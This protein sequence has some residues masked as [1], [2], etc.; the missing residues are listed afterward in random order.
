MSV[1]LVLGGATGIGAAGV[2]ALRGAGHRVVIADRNL[3]SARALAAEDL[4][5]DAFAIE[6]DLADPDIPR[7]AVA[8]ASEL[9]GGTI[10]VV[11]YNA[12]VLISHPL[13]EWTTADWGRSVAVN[14]SGPFLTAVAADSALKASAAGRFIVTSSTGALRG[15]AGMPAYHATKSGLLG[16]IRALADEWGPWG[17][18]ANALLPGWVETAFNDPFW[19]SQPD[20]TRAEQELVSR[21]PLRRQGTPEDFS[22]AV[23]F[24][25]SEAS[26]YMTGQALIVDG[27]YSAV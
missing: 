10:D 13:P 27:G 2:R 6:A 9:G 26:A 14:L 12:G 20:P 15:H 3:D 25:A 8:Y 4:G 18:T 16:L 22:G 17:I 24:L 7:G 11:F 23:A 1:A 21:I 5:P 19:S